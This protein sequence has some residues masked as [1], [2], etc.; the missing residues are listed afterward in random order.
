MAAKN[1]NAARISPTLKT[2]LGS[3]LPQVHP[4]LDAFGYAPFAGAIAE[5][6]RAT[7]SP[8]GL[9][10]AIDGPWGAGKT[11]LL[12]FVRHYLSPEDNASS[13]ADRGTPVVVD[14][15]PW[16]F[17]DRE[18]LAMQFLAQLRARFPSENKILMSVADALAEYADAI[19]SAVSVS[20]AAG[21]GFPVPMMKES[22]SFFLKKFKRKAKDVP[23]LK[24]EISKALRDSGQ[25]FVVFIDDIDRLT[26]EEVREVFKVIKA[27]ADFPNVVYVLAFD[28]R[29][30]S[31]SL[32]VALGIADGNAYLEKI[33]QAQFALPA[34]S[35]QLVLDKF[36]SDLNVLF[37]GLDDGAIGIDHTHWANVFHDGVAPF[38]E[39]PRDVV[40]AIN[41]LLVTF[42]GIR[43]EVNPV[44]FIALECLRVFAPDAYAVI[45]DNKDRFTGVA[46]DRGE[47]ADERTFH[48]GWLGLLEEKYQEHVKALIL[49]LFPRTQ[50]VWGNVHHG[51]SS[52]RHWTVEARVCI[53]D[54]FDRYFRFSLS[55]HELGERELRDFIGL[56]DDVDALAA[57]WEAA[58]NQRRPAGTGKANDLIDALTERDD[59]PARFAKAC[60]DAFFRVGDQ[61]VADPRNALKH[62]FSIRPEIQVYWLVHH[63][64]KVIPD[65][66]RA[67]IVLEEIRN[68]DAIVVACHVAWSIA[69]MHEPDAEERDSVFR[70]FAAGRVDEM[71]SIVV[72]RLHDAARAGTLCDLPHVHFL[73]HVWHT[74]AG[75][76]TVQDWFQTVLENDN[77]IL[78]LLVDARRIGTSQTAGNRVV[79]R[80]VSMDPHEFEPYLRA[81]TDLEAFA[82]RIGAL[83]TKQNLTDDE[84][85][86]IQVF[87][88]G[89][90]L[91]RSGRNPNDPRARRGL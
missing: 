2:P 11:S 47:R 15:N 1:Q 7:P 61:F 84:R 69:R 35:H 20:M 56:G 30:V 16:W 31:E 52:L 54:K 43:D 89:M 27:I 60:L 33:V 50:A 13:T 53:S 12:N 68:G 34:V 48:E 65:A 88:Q 72:Q 51:N 67:A 64:A 18:Q 70:Q 14:F 82:T 71:K 8:Q 19:G 10:M 6:T 87:G 37:S 41:A 74:W 5:A 29:V 62:F 83:A 49:R 3:D 58:N 39:T 36:V 77:A 76:T 17:A 4:S 46:P 66:D 38:I 55:P 24:D 32:R 45:R 22:I 28:R 75:D 78:R 40:R 44:D 73:L 26:P 25:R 79:D 80:I 85:E 90:E 91:I 9:V 81:P 42:P 59:L 63:L 23:K 86:A 21:A 57:A